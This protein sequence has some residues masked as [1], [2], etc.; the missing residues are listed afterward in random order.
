MRYDHVR[1]SYYLRQWRY[2]EE[3]REYLP[4][5]SIEQAKVFFNALKTLTDDE[6]Q[7]LI[8]KYYKSEKLCNYN[9]DLGCYTSLIPITDSVIAEQYGISKN[10]YMKKRASI[11]AKLGRAMTESQQ[12]VNEKLTEFKLKIG[13][14][15]YYVRALK[16]EYLYF[17]SYVIGSVLDAAV[18][19]LP[20]DEYLVNKLLGN[21]F[22][23]EP[24]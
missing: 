13:D 2:Y 1:P 8:D 12:L 23:K 17:D 22:E 18:L 16:R 10:D 7:V 24:I 6:R 9:Y 21:G 15:F 4:K 20:K 3:A 19:T 5:R 14:G 11:E